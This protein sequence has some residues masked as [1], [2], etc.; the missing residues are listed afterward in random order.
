M[1]VTEQPCLMLMFSEILK[2][3]GE[4]RGLAVSAKPG[5]NI[6]AT[7]LHLSPHIPDKETEAR[8][9]SETHQSSYSC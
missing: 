5:P 4:H 8:A 3:P 1:M 7:F 6:R 2:F 9:V